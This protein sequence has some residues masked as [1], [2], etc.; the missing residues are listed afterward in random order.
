VVGTPSDLVRTAT[1][2]F[3]G[4]LRS[5]MPLA[6]VAAHLEREGP[7]IADGGWAIDL[8][9]SPW[10]ALGLGCA[11]LGEVLVDKLPFAPSRLRPLPLSGRVV[12]AGT[13]CALWS[14]AQGR[15]SDSGAL[16]GSLGGVLGS[17]AGY[18]LRTRLPRLLRVPGLV[19]A[20]V[21]DGLAFWLGRWAVQR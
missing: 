5:V 7:D 18:S 12:L 15:T 14:L 6:I 10:G 9:A 11:A 17:V 8:L 20:V 13:A 1:L 21:E 16:V 19:V 3:V 4:G 2:G